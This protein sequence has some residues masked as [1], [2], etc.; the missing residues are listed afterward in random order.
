[1]VFHMNTPKRPPRQ[2]NTREYSQRIPLL[3]EKFQRGSPRISSLRGLDQ[4]R[5]GFLS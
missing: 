3:R 5:I 2:V 1:M 4:D